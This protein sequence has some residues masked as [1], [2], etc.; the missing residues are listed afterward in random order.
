MEYTLSVTDVADAANRLSIA[1]PLVEYNTS[2]GGPSQYRHLAV[3]LKDCAGKVVGGVWGNTAYD[4]LAIYL[5]SVPAASRGR[6]IGTE[7][8]RLAESAAAARGCHGVWLDTLEFQ[9]RGFYEHID[10]VCFCELPHYPSGYSKYFMKKEFGASV[11]SSNP[12][13]ER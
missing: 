9:A 13:I 8:M 10:Y 2:H 3:L 7:L 12:P 6:G 11:V 5:L 4:W 1:A